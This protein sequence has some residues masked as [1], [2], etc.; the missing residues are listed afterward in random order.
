MISVSKNMIEKARNTLLE[1]YVTFKDYIP[2][3]DTK[4]HDYL[5]ENM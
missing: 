2:A 4:Y 3:F 5:F 1:I